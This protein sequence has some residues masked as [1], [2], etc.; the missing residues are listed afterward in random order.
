ML[1]KL[2]CLSLTASCQINAEMISVHS[3]NTALLIFKL[4]NNIC[5]CFQYM[6]SI[7]PSHTLVD[8]PEIINTHDQQM[9]SF[10]FINAFL[11]ILQ[12]LIVIHKTCQHV[13]FL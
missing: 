9:T 10:P 11:N 2:Y 13:N 5:S 12:H 6:I 3:I 1:K 4:I 7:I 8:L